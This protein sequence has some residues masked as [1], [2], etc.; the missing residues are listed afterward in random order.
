MKCEKCR[1]YEATF[2]KVININGHIAEQHLCEKCASKSNITSETFNE[3]LSEF[4]KSEGLFNQ[5]FFNNNLFNEKQNKSSIMIDRKSEYVVDDNKIN[6]QEL[7]TTKKEKKLN[8]LN[9]ELEKAIKEERYEDASKI[10]S[11]INKIEKGE[12]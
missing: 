12:N 1:K 9:E 11:E 7:L 3:I 6:L 10:K 8:K 2:H 4:K 5:S